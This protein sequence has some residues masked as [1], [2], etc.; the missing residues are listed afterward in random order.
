M[1]SYSWS[2]STKCVH[3][4]ECFR[5]DPSNFSVF[6]NLVHLGGRPYV[7]TIARLMALPLYLRVADRRAMLLV[8]MEESIHYLY[9]LLAC[10]T[11]RSQGHEPFPMS[12]MSTQN[13]PLLSPITDE[14]ISIVDNKGV[15]SH[16]SKTFCV[17]ARYSSTIPSSPC[18]VQHWE[19]FLLQYTPHFYPIPHRFCHI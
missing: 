15:S 7:I 3:H 17:R 18:L 16:L 9:R 13:P 19:P 4:G 12:M 1:H 11:S 14:Q 5:R 2:F 8:V 6:L 10:S